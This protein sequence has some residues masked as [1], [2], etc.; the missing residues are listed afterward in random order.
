MSGETPA[1]IASRNSSRPVAPS[2][3][4]G[5][6]ALTRRSGTRSHPLLPVRATATFTSVNSSV[7]SDSSGV[8]LSR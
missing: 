2:A 3:F 7:L 8:I 5:N 1:F 6:C 4:F